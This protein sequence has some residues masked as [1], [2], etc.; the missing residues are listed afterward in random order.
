MHLGEADQPPG[1]AEK[2]PTTLER[3]AAAPTVSPAT[4]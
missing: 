3:Y 4:R 2:L 1:V